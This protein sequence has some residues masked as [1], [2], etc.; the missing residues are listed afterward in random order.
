VLAERHVWEQ[1]RAKTKKSKA[2]AHDKLKKKISHTKRIPRGRQ[3]PRR[4]AKRERH[5]HERHRTLAAV[6]QQ[7]KQ[8]GQVST[9]VPE[10]A[11]CAKRHDIEA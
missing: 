2:K 1:G 11:R 4:T 10:L 3:K 7:R 9:D 5:E 8:H 6:E